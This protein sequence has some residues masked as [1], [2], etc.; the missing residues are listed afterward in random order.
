MA[1]NARGIHV[2]P[3]IYG[4]DVDLT[5]AVKSLGIT[6]T[7]LVGESLRGPAFQAL[8]IANW[9]DYVETF[10]GTSTEKFKEV[11]ILNTKHHILLNHIYQSLKILNSSEYWA[12]ADTMQV[13]HG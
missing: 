5:Y 8:D 12:L 1:D 4:R 9:R 2:S 6:K 7:G 11:S 10:G 3:G 13:Q